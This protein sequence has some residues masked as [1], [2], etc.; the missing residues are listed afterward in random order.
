[1]AETQRALVPSDVLQPYFAPCTGLFY[2][3]PAYTCTGG[4]VIG[5][6][7]YIDLLNALFILFLLNVF[8]IGPI[9]SVLK[10][11]FHF[12]RGGGSVAA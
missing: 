3:S 2:P 4:W 5:K 12:R 11:T 10:C 9:L 1:L 7:S 6:K 8:F